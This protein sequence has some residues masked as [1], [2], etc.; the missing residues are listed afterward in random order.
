MVPGVSVALVR[1]LLPDGQ[2][3][4]AVGAQYSGVAGIARTGGVKFCSVYPGNAGTSPTL[5]RCSRARPG[6]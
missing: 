1:G 6:L 2:I 3:A 5:S 4:V